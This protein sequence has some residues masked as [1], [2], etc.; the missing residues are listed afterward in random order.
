MGFDKWK[1]KHVLISLIHP[2]SIPDG[3]DILETT[4]LQGVINDVVGDYV[5]VGDGEEDNFIIAKSNIG[6]MTN[7]IKEIDEDTPDASKLLL[8]S[9]FGDDEDIH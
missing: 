2:F 4:I 3:N 5:F 1:G 8:M 9:D 7:L 6:L